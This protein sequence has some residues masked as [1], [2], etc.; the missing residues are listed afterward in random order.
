[1]A[2]ISQVKHRVIMIEM[3]ARIPATSVNLPQI[4]ENGMPEQLWGE[5]N[6]RGKGVIS[7]GNKKSLNATPGETSNLPSRFMTN[8][9]FIS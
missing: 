6:F 4:K 5:P 2:V 7:R 1:M 9:K 3:L 8:G